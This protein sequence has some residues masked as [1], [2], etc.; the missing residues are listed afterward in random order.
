MDFILTIRPPYHHR[1]H[2]LFP[3]PTTFRPNIL[4]IGPSCINLLLL[5]RLDVA[6]LPIF[7]LTATCRGSCVGDSRIN[8]DNHHH[9]PLL[10]MN[11]DRNGCS[12]PSD[13]MEFMEFLAGAR[14]YF[15]FKDRR[16]TCKCTSLVSTL[17]F[18]YLSRILHLSVYPLLAF[19]CLFFVSDIHGWMTYCV[20]G[21]DDEV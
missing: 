11:H 10:L 17:F 14:N 13:M 5:V 16:E 4:E 3:S 2:L 7:V 6:S 8:F 15:L 21:C 9:L 20:A 1:H 12:I 19:S 18:P